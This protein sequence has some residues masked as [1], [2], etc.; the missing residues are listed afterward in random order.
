M[1]SKEKRDFHLYQKKN[2]FYNQIIKRE[3][4][5]KINSFIHYLKENFFCLI[6]LKQKAKAKTEIFQI[7]TK[8]KIYKHFALIIFLHSPEFFFKDTNK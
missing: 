2:H 5:G 1:I 6:S 7:K 3:N 4:W 8:K